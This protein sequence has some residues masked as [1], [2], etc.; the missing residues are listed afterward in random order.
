MSQAASVT[1]I[2]RIMSQAA[3]VGKAAAQRNAGDTHRAWLDKKYKKRAWKRR[4]KALEEQPAL[5]LATC[6]W[7]ELLNFG[8]GNGKTKGRDKGSASAKGTGKRRPALEDGKAKGKD[9]GKIESQGREG[10]A[11]GQALLAMR[12][13]KGGTEA[14]KREV[15]KSLKELVSKPA[16][17]KRAGYR[18]L[19]KAWHPDKRGDE[20]VFK[21]LQCGKAALNLDVDE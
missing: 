14:G 1:K 3:S 11:G 15:L 9:R 18:R 12:D 21:Y 10:N 4:C 6:S 8:K 13:Q 2:D 19:A 16:R 5:D 7:H 20:E 17:E